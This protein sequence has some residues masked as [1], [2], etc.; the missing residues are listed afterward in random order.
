MTV[1][2]MTNLHSKGIQGLE[3]KYKFRRI[4]V[5]FVAGKSGLGKY[6]TRSQIFMP[7]TATI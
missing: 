2:S 7:Y 4:Q 3:L 5:R 1:L 6:T